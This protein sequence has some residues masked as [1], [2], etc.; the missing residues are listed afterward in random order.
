MKS[1]LA[2]SCSSCTTSSTSLYFSG[3]LVGATGTADVAG[4]V[5]VLV[6]GLVVPMGYGGSVVFLPPLV[7]TLNTY[8]GL[9][10]TGATADNF[11]NFDSSLALK[12]A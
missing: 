11:D 6:G 2:E 5:G 10:A 12:I 1:C 7:Q 8:S 3:A 9:V 4:V